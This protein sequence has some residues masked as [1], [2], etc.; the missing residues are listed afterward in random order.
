[1]HVPLWDSKTN[2][3]YLS[4]TVL[5]MCCRLNNVIW[6]DFGCIIFESLLS[7]ALSEKVKNCPKEVSNS[8]RKNDYLAPCYLARSNQRA[9]KTLLPR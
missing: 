7:Q 9:R 5:D 2:V 3:D 1:M 6:L 8:R 4:G